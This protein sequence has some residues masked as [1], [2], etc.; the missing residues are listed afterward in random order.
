MLASN[1][2]LFY[3]A[4]ASAN[5]VN[6]TTCGSEIACASIMTSAS[7]SSIASASK[8]ACLHKTANVSKIAD[9]S[10]SQVQVIFLIRLCD[11]PTKIVTGA[12]Q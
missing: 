10:K 7:A 5:G 8:L 2:H 12:S 9:A 3:A 1:L 4:H 6:C 11:A